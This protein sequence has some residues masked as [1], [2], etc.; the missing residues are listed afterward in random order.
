MYFK[1]SVCVTMFLNLQLIKISLDP[2]QSGTKSAP[3]A[4]ESFKP[5]QQPEKPK[6]TSEPPVQVNGSGSHSH[7]SKASVT[8]Q[9]NVR[10]FFIYMAYCCLDASI[11]IASLSL[12]WIYIVNTNFKVCGFSKFFNT[13]TNHVSPGH[14]INNSC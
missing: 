5:E 12:Q 11:W 10:G 14:N 1:G 6:A 8:L 3:V 2:A 9:S 4:T 13:L 7:E